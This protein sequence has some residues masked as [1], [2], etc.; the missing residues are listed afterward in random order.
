MLRSSHGPLPTSM[1]VS[2][3]TLEQKQQIGTKSSMASAIEPWALVHMNGH[4]NR[5]ARPL[6]SSGESPA[7]CTHTILNDHLIDDFT[8]GDTAPPTHTIMPVPARPNEKI[9]RIHKAMAAMTTHLTI[10][11]VKQGDPALVRHLSY[12]CN[13]SRLSHS[14]LYET[15]Y[16]VAALS[17]EWSTSPMCENST[18]LT[19]KRRTPWRNTTCV[20]SSLV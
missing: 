4:A 16:T 5:L 6:F 13:E 11:P 2:S 1:F 15:T 12:P 20:R 19:R 17:S 10:A 9:L 3:R 18:G 8:T 7:P 14:V